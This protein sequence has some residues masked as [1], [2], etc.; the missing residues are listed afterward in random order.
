MDNPNHSY[1]VIVTACVVYSKGKLCSQLVLYM[2][3][4]MMLHVC[5]AGLANTLQQGTQTQ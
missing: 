5:D 1:I 4:L 3:K 2:K